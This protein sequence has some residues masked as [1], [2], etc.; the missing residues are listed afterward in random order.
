MGCLIAWVCLSA[1]AAG[2]VPTK[3][4]ET[5]FACL[6]AL[7]LASRGHSSQWSHGVFAITCDYTSLKSAEGL[8]ADLK[9]GF[10]KYLALPER[11]KSGAAGWRIRVDAIDYRF[12]FQTTVDSVK[13]IDKGITRVEIR[14]RPHLNLEISVPDDGSEPKRWWKEAIVKT[15]ALTEFELDR[16]IKAAGSY[17]ENL[18][19]G[20]RSYAYLDG[21]VS[22][23]LLRLQ[24]VLQANGY[25][26]AHTKQK[27]VTFYNLKRPMYRVVFY[28]FN[29]SGRTLTKMIW[30]W[31][32]SKGKRHA[33]NPDCS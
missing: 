13:S 30:F 33:T 15:S 22:D 5:P 11:T 23:A 14:E 31:S 25:L 27:G 16:S 9:K 24:G 1:Q 6:K 8:Y 18:S 3:D 29:Q 4:V 21:S 7:T 28:E 12:R 26:Q 2:I 32:K 10:S 20:Q 19:V 17:P